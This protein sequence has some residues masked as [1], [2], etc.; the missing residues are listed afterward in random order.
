[1][2]GAWLS[3]ACLV[4]SSASVAVG[5]GVARQPPEPRIVSIVRLIAH[6][7]AY[8][9]TR[10]RI[11]GF[12]A[13]DRSLRGAVYL[14]KEDFEHELPQQAIRFDSQD[15]DFLREHQSLNRQYVL[16]NGVFRAN[17]KTAKDSF[18]GRLTL[19]KEATRW[20]FRYD[21]DEGTK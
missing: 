4:L 7:N 21:S 3:I 5:Q 8:D 11:V 2:A 20:P 10:V 13:L 12:L 17:A 6:P 1:M 16:I 18:A 15:A 9:G 19:L 14:H